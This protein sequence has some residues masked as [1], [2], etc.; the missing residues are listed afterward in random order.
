M[1]A[2]LY[3]PR[4]ID[5][6]YAVRIA[7][8]LEHVAA[9]DVAQRIRRPLAPAQQ[10]LHAIGAIKPRLFRHEP[11]GLAFR[12]GQQTINEGAGR[13]TNLRALESLADPALQRH[14]LRLPFQKRPRPVRNHPSRSL[15][16]NH[17]GSKYATVVLT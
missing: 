17:I 10:R 6:Q 7:K 14:K 11:A 8:R 16:R 3:E 1:L 9:H 13:F 5:H 4:L 2:F 12:A 15:G